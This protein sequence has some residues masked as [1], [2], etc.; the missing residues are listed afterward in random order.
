MVTVNVE[1]LKFFVLVIAFSLTARIIV[2][3]NC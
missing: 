1:A 2:C 3:F